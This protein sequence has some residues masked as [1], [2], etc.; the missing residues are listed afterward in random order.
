LFF[1]QIVIW[2]F[3]DQAFDI[4]ARH[5]GKHNVRLSLVVTQIVDAH[6]MGM[7]AHLGHSPGF[8]PD[9]GESGLI[10]LLNLDESES[11]LPVLDGI[12]CKI[13]LLFAA[14][15]QELLDLVTA[16][17]EGGRLGLDWLFS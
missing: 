10:Q 13:D 6:D 11:H 14:L 9:T 1:G 17:G 2:S 16:I 8:S 4:P 15:A 3:L 12:M 7:V 5:D